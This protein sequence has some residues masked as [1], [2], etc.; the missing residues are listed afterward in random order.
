MVVYSPA[1][2]AE[3][4]QGAE[5]EDEPAEGAEV[6]IEEQSEEGYEVTP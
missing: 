3:A 2:V 4:A 5:K 1:R 6:S